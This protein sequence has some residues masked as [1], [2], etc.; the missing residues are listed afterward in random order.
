MISGTNGLLGAADGAFL[1][2]KDKRT[3]N[4]ATLEISGRDQQDQKLM[5]RRN[6]ETLLWELERSETELW[7]EPAEPILQKIAEIV[8][9]ENPEWQ[10]SPTDLVNLLSLDIQPNTLTKKLNINAA[11]LLNDFGIQ[12]ESRRTHDG[13]I[14]AFHRGDSL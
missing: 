5:L 7:K 9:A 8:T 14:V 13:R 3:S 6:P 11:K 1:L 4:T 10:G 12:Y 2:Q